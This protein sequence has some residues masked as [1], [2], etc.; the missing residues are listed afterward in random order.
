MSGINWGLARSN[1]FENA[2]TQGLQLG[3]V[4][5]EAQDRKELRA[6]LSVI[7]TD[8][9]NQRALSEVFQR[10]PALGARLMDRADDA[11]FRRDTGEY[12]GGNHL[13][14]FGSPSPVPSQ[15]NA[16]LGLTASQPVAA[17]TNPPDATPAVSPGAGFDQAFA[18]YAEPRS[19]ETPQEQQAPEVDLSALGE[20]QDGRDRAFLRMMRR[21]PIKAIKIKSVLRDN[22]VDQLQAERDAYS[23][24]IEVLSRATDQPSWQQALQQVAPRFQ[25]IGAD[26]L[27]VVP[28]AFP[29]EEGVRQLMGRALPIKERLDLFLREAN[30]EADNARA[31]RNTDSMIATR[32]RRAAEYERNNRA[33]LETTRRGQDMT[34]KRVREGRKP[35]V[36]TVKTP[37]E[38]KRL[39]P[40]TLY[41]GPDGQVRER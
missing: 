18:P 16:L 22:F 14:G 26:L 31:D 39:K 20:P 8:P 19:A 21:D 41:R 17:A 6:A 29:G 23:F 12:V 28:T 30:I 33:R 7:A 10:D 38:A 36:V 40:G 3:R 9:E 15:P 11:A 13:L 1:V 37:A 32:E 24:G 35:K 4:M 25:A 2:L 34:D 27:S 5:R